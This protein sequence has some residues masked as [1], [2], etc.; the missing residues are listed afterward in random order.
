VVSDSI[1]HPTIE[2]IRTQAGHDHC[3]CA[4]TVSRVL[5]EYQ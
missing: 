4:T 2:T 3:S 1:C 5:A